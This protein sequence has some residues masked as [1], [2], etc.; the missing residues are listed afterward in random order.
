MAGIAA[1]I[2]STQ[3]KNINPHEIYTRIASSA[4]P[5]SNFSETSILECKQVS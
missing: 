1:L 4:T 3:G 2:M 5:V